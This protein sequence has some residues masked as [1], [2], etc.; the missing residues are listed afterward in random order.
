MGNITIT[1][2]SGGGRARLGAFGGNV[3]FN[4][5]TLFNNNRYCVDAVVTGA[6]LRI[7][8]IDRGRLLA[9]FRG[10]PGA[11]IGCVTFLSRG[12]HFLGGGLGMIS[13]ANDRGAICG[14]LA[15]LTSRGNRVSSLGGVSLVSQALNVDHTDLCHTLSSLRRGKCVVGRGGGVGI[16]CG[17]GVG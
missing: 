1:V 8:F 2:S 5:T 15:S 4:T 6:G 14:C 17:R 16:V 12:M 13:S 10:C 7:L 3:S 9:V 11:T